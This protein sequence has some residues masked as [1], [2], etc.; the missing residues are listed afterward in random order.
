MVKKTMQLVRVL[1]LAVLASGSVQGAFF[2]TPEQK[3]ANQKN[4][5]ATKKPATAVTESRKSLSWPEVYRRS[6]NS[7]VQIFA[8]TNSF[9]ILEPYK[10]P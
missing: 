6:K 5:V 2:S 1:L 9:N 10:A 8:Y 3:N 4:V 7:V